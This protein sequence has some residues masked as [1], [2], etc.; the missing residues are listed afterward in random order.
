MDDDIVGSDPVLVVDDDNAPDEP[1]DP[2]ADEYDDS[3][4]G[5][6]ERGHPVPSTHGSENAVWGEGE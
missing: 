1:V 4:E 3:E 6:T 2:N 5:A